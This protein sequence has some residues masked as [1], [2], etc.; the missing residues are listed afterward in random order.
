MGHYFYINQTKKQFFNVGLFGQSSEFESIGR[1]L[2]AR[3]FGLLCSEFGS[4]Y[5]DKIC[6]TDNSLKGFNEYVNINIE[7]ELFLIDMEGV[8]ILDEVIDASMDAFIQVCFYAQIQQREDL[9]LFLNKRYG[10]NTW[11]EM[12]RNFMKNRSDHF[13]CRFYEARDRGIELK[14]LAVG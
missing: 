7:T 13:T 14:R 9:M 1:E 8:E 3:A 10:K 4:W 5:N 11:Q 12:Q 2:G 6:I